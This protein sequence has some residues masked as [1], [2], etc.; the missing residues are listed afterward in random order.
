[1]PAF[2]SGKPSWILSQLANQ[3]IAAAGAVDLI[4]TDTIWEDPV[5]FDGTSTVT[6]DRPGLY[7]IGAHVTRAAAAS[8]SPITVRLRQNGVTIV[9]SQSSSVA[10]TLTVECH[11]LLKCSAGDQL[12]VNVTFHATLSTTTSA[13][14]TEFWGARVGP[15]RW[16]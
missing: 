7:L 13:P 3:T 6:V 8:G 12:V 9:L 15:E 14:S 11:R 4:W 2:R 5:V 10:G 16:T 1:M